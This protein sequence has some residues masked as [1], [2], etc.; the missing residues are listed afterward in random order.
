MKKISPKYALASVTLSA[1]IVL[2]RPF[3]ALKAYATANQYDW[4]KQ[5]NLDRLAGEY[6][7]SAMSANGKHIILSVAQGGTA[8]AQ[9]SPLY[10]TNDGGSNWE[11][12]APEIDPGIRNDWVAVDTSNDGQTMVVASN[13]GYNIDSASYIDGKIFISKNSGDTWDDITPAGDPNWGRVV[14]S[15]DGSKIAAVHWGHGQV[16]VSENDGADWSS[17]QV[18]PLEGDAW[19][20]KSIAIS[21]DGDKMLVGGENGSDFTTQTYLSDNSGDTWAN[22]SPNID[23]GIYFSAL[24]MSDDGNK[25]AVA[26]LGSNGGA[27][28]HVFVSEN[29][30][31]DWNDITPDT[32]NDNSWTGVAFSGDGTKLS[33]ID[34]NSLG[35]MYLSDN[36]GASWLEEDPGQGTE[37]SSWKTLALNSDGT[38]AIVASQSNAY[39]AGITSPSVTL[40]DAEG[41]K[42]IM[43]TTPKGTTITCHS[44]VKESNLDTKDFAYSY[45]LGFVDF[46]FSGAE[47]SNEISLLFVTNL[48]PSQVVIRKYNPI[49]KQYATITTATVTETTYQSQHALQVTYA[50]QDNGPLD[51]NPNVGEIADPVGLAVA[52]ITV[53]NTGLSQSANQGLGTSPTFLLVGFTLASGI[54]ITTTRRKTTPRTSSNK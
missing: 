6:N 9:E 50:I 31:A 37:E 26:N 12:V 2:S 36:T 35:K 30:G 19:N 22:I 20:L 29:N 25:I 54:A 49:S 4:T 27:N 17:I 33:V 45:P 21:N 28:D 52:D 3:Y 1:A 16:M 23:D 14:V 8:D 48:K 34:N 51:V 40:N 11:N 13:S 53:P 5:V 46:C 38:A 42:T 44:G 7:S 41:G 24:A 10:I 39:V 18:N 43:L 32:V 47:A 15:G